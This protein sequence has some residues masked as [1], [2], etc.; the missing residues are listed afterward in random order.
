MNS[1]SEEDALHQ[2]KQ[3]RYL[4][5]AIFLLYFGTALSSDPQPLDIF[6]AESNSNARQVIAETQ[7]D[8]AELALGKVPA[9]DYW[10]GAK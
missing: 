1:V 8:W 10:I 5:V 3:Q 9:K 7:D 2:L 4:L 6:I